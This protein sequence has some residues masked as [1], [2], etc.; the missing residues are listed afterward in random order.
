MSIGQ[1]FQVGERVRIK[2][3]VQAGTDRVFTVVKVEIVREP[4]ASPGLA[5]RLKHLEYTL[6]NNTSYLAGQLISDSKWCACSSNLEPNKMYS[7]VDAEEY[8]K[9]V[10]ER[11]YLRVSLAHIHRKTQPYWNKL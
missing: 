5:G 10:E 7:L 11:D 1:D 2:K 6:D 4:P 3:Q 9:L 8:R